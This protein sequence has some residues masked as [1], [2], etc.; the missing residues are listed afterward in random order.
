M[1]GSS[2]L[3][4]ET[5]EFGLIIRIDIARFCVEWV[6]VS[7]KCVYNMEYLFS[8]TGNDWKAVVGGVRLYGR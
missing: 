5:L 3:V 4:M 8:T 7:D 2:A 1:V 6:Y